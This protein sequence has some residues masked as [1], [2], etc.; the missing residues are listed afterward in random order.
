MLTAAR[1]VVTRDER[2]TYGL[3][4][5]R[6]L[7]D[8]DVLDAIVMQWGWDPRGTGRVK[9]DP[10]RT[11]D[12]MSDAVRRIA[13]VSESGGRIAFAT[14]RPASLLHLM[15]HLASGATRRGAR[16]LVDEYGGEFGDPG[17]R[18]LSLGWIAGVAVV[19]DSHDL[20]RAAGVEAGDEL[21]F[22]LPRPDLVVAD[23]GFAGRA[24]SD[25]LETVVF[26]DLDA[27]GFG[28]T[29]RP[30]PTHVVP[31]DDRR[32]SADYWPLCEV[33]NGRLG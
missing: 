27:P 22:C 3:D 33:A 5:C 24:V 26:A 31:I 29:T 4:P 32:R 2:F 23:G 9:I 7:T 30:A 11:I 25:D 18:G 13:E 19:T 20:V 15:T 21:L 14:S 6:A 16:V 8:D 10:D 17:R 12:A 1:G 28:V